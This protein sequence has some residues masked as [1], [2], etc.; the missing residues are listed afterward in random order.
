MLCIF[1]SVNSSRIWYFCILEIHKKIHRIVYNFNSD[2]FELRFLSRFLWISF[3]VFDFDK[4]KYKCH[5]K[6]NLIFGKTNTVM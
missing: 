4:E 3:F 5:L 2:I 6:K 1:L